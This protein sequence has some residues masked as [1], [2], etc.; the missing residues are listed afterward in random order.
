[1]F[2]SSW[3]EVSPNAL[4]GALLKTMSKTISKME[5]HPL[6]EIFQQGDDRTLSE[7]ADDIARNGLND[8][9][10]RY[11]GRILD[12]RNR[13]LACK[14][15]GVEP[16]FEEYTGDKPF[17]FVI[18]KNLYRRHLDTS[19]RGMLGQ[20]VYELVSRDGTPSKMTVEQIAKHFKVGTTIVKEAGKVVAGGSES[21]Q[22]S[23]Q[24]GK[25]SVHKAATAVRDA[26]KATGIKVKKKTTPEDKEKVRKAAD[27]ILMKE[28]TTL[29]PVK[30][31]EAKAEEFNDK[32]LAGEYN[33]KLCQHNI[34]KMT[35]M[36]ATMKA[37]SMTWMDKFQ[38]LY[39]KTFELV[40]YKEDESLMKGLLG[41]IDE[42]NSS[43]AERATI[44]QGLWTSKGKT[45][46]SDD[47][48]PV[49]SSGDEDIKQIRNRKDSFT[50]WGRIRC[51]VEDGNEV[52]FERDILPYYNGDCERAL[53]YLGYY[54]LKE[55][56]GK[57]EDA[58]TVA[59]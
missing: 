55:T 10:V 26:E 38:P 44:L 29:L 40:A 52:L 21:M 56:D 27:R 2:H 33:G 25:V 8:P 43:F 47:D 7:M 58:I 54:C 1:M 22:K 5:L 51:L 24:E 57:V 42:V 34:V 39:C 31:D 45:S 23:V 30:P 48:D 17:E 50:F 28:P 14:M 4:K 53:E 49:S 19:Q 11:E 35:K 13:F 3:F 36:V 9:I 32:V 59:P 15:A 12:G 6:C 41:S 20:K 16:R 37:N 46:K 18:S